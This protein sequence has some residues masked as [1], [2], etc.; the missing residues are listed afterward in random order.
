MNV[1]FLSIGEFDDI[2]AGSVHIDIIKEFAKHHNVFLV[3]KRERRKGKPTELSVEHGINILRVKTG[4]LKNV[5]MI[6]KG[7]S[8]LRIE[9]QYKRAIKKYFKGVKFDLILYS[10]PPITFAKVVKYIKKRDDA[11]T[12]LLLKDIFPQ[13]AVDLGILSK[14]GIKGLLY[15]FF[16]RKEKKLYAFSDKIGCMS[17]ANCK[18]V[19]DNNAEV[20][21]EK[22]EVC[23]NSVQYK[24]MRV[25]EQTAKQIR[26][27]YQIPLDKK[28]FVYGGNL[29]RPKG[30]PFLIECLKAQKENQNAYFLI[31]GDGAE[32]AKLQ[33][34]VD[35]EKPCNVKLMKRLPKEDYDKMVAGCDVGM[36][37]FRP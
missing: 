27:K 22:V 9:G 31:V 25:D 33:E 35:L 11:K 8:T 34:F 16:R 4:N 37:F 26:E 10:T 20:L 17:P 2:S 13:N 1:L 6:E 29:G 32:F 19:L 28:V 14:K 36:I 23:P 3:A 12:Y 7:I 30:I 15:K 24:D 18:F 21:P 5:G